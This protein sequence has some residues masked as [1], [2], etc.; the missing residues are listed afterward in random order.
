MQKSFAPLILTILN[1]GTEL[2]SEIIQRLIYQSCF[3]TDLLQN[4]S[5]CWI[6]CIIVCL[7][8][9]P[10]RGINMY[11]IGHPSVQLKQS[12]SFSLLL[13]NLIIRSMTFGELVSF[14]LRIALHEAL[15]RNLF[16]KFLTNAKE[17]PCL[18]TSQVYF[19][20]HQDHCLDFGD[21]YTSDQ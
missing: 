12:C 14:S 8:A 21:F 3:I 15:S 6:V 19:G 5:R 18:S 1:R 2:P 16:L 20:Q 13:S 10:F 9:Q 17:M 7:D 4:S 11:R